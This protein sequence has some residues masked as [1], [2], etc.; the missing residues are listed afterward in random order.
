MCRLIGRWAA[1]ETCLVPFF[2]SAESAMRSVCDVSPVLSRVCGLLKV[3]S[4]GHEACPCGCKN[5]QP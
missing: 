4:K 2:G 1:R 5:G 3:V